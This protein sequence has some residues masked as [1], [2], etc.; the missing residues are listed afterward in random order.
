M[1]VFMNAP[2]RGNV[3]ELEHVIERLVLLCRSEEATLADLPKTMVLEPQGV[4]EPQFGDQVIPIRELQRRYASWA[5]QR[6]SGAK[7]ATCEAL[8]IDSKTL[9]KW[10]R[11]ESTLDKEG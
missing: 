8:G 9:A 2:W 4:T 5:L 10:L 6:F 3:R 1:E 11:A 7:L